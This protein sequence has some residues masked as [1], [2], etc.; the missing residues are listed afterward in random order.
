ME[1]IA[2]DELVRLAADDPLQ[3]DRDALVIS[4]EVKGVAIE[5]KSYVLDDFKALKKK[6]DMV[7]H[8]AVIDVN[9]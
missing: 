3:K 6:W 1:A 9:G 5:M 8:K 4:G 2:N 7:N